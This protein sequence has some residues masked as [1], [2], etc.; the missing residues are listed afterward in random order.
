MPEL[1]FMKRYFIL[2]IFLLS[3]AS[4]ATAQTT[5]NGIV[6]DAFTH[7]ALSGVV[8][9]VA[10]SGSTTVLGTTNSTGRFDI[11][12][13]QNQLLRLSMIGYTPR[14]VKNTTNGGKLTINVTM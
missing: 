1:S 5:V 11:S 4:V 6:T 8:V 9:S 12:S 2:F 13:T 3:I 14:I 10:D 7:E